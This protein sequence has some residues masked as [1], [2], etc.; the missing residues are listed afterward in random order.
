[1]TLTSRAKQFRRERRHRERVLTAAKRRLAME[2][3]APPRMKR[4]PVTDN[5]NQT[6]PRRP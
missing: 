5:D 3:L 6:S 2:F 4:Q 1:M